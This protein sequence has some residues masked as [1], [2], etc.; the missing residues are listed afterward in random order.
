M[1]STCAKVYQIPGPQGPAGA[2]GADGTNGTNGVNAYTTL[3][4]N[5]NM[6]GEGITIDVEVGTTAWMVIG[7]ILYVETWGYME[8]DTILSGTVVRLLNL[9]NTT[10]HEYDSNA[11][12]GIQASA[13]SKVSPGGLQG[14]NGSTTGAYLEIANNLGDG[15]LVAATCRTNLGASAIGDSLF[16]VPSSSAVTFVRVNADDSVTLRS[17]SDFRT[18]L[19]L[20]TM[21]VQA[22]SAVAITGGT[23]TGITNLVASGGTLATMTSIATATFSATGAATLSGA[24]SCTS[25]GSVTMGGTLRLTPSAL[26]TLGAGNA[27]TAN[28]VKVRVVGNGAPVTIGATPSVTAG[29]ADGQLLLIMGTHNTNTVTLQRESALPGSTLALGAATRVLGANDMLLLCWDSTVSLWAEI[30]FVDN[31]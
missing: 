2:D 27:V 10:A 11:N 9:K 3:S 12:V 29:A 1:A 5:Y 26:Q 14:Y 18:D 21:A 15:G 13:N 7:Q 28:A 8:V 30:A 4:A 23:A 17:A 22:A 31:T 6:P 16:T 20:G 24:V 25:A 19:G